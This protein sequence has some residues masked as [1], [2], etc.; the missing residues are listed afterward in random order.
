MLDRDATKD[1]VVEAG[2]ACL[3]HAKAQGAGPSF[4][5]PTL[6]FGIG[7]LPAGAVVLP[8]SPLGFGPGAPRPK[9]F[10]GAE[11]R[12]GVARSLEL[13]RHRAVAI[14]PLGLPVRSFI[15]PEAQPFEAL[16]NRCHQFRL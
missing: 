8:R 13:R 14:E 1:A 11:A 2:L 3:R 9:L 12:I 16:E 4:G 7:E 10:D 15:P 6:A 5:A